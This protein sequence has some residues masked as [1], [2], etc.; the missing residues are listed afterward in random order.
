MTQDGIELFRKTELWAGL[1]RAFETAVGTSPECLLM[2][3]Q[4]YQRMTLAEYRG[5]GT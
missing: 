5:V 2:E 4:A 3:E 1:A